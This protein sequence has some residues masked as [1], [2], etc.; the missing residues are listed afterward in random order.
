MKYTEYK[1]QQQQEFNAL[2]LFW[3]Y[4]NEQFEKALNERGIA[5]ED[6][7][8]Y[9]YK[10]SALGAFYLK[11]DA[12]IIK[13]YFEKDRNKELI[14]IMNND[15]D[16]AREAFEYEMYNHEYPIN[17]QGDYDVAS[18]FGNCV[19]EEEKTGIDYLQEIG[20][21]SNA[22]AEFNNARRKVMSADC[23]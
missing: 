21:N 2:P 20:M 12:S 23:W 9:V 15:A 16:F 3:A 1:E 22:I 5:L 17:W 10:S 7:R 11:K 13:D 14:D 8:E 6:A 4:S 18:C 19:Y